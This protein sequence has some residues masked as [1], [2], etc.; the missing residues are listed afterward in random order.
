M[1]NPFPHE[2]PALTAAIA[3]AHS[4]LKSHSAD[5]AEYA[6][7]VN[8]LTKLYN[9]QNNLL[10]AYQTAQQFEH[11]H[12]LN[13]ERLGLEE[14]AA[15]KKFWERISPDT[16]LTVAAN[17]AIATLVTKY[18]RTGVIRTVIKDFIK[19]I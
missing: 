13:L 3:S 4:D 7:A 15:E 17:L 2:D 12:S 5:S 11:E 1:I 10:Q 9:I 14:A 16:A 6:A 19:K 8:Q 18:E